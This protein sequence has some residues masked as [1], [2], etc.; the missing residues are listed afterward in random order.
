MTTPAPSL[1]QPLPLP[2]PAK[3]TAWLRVRYVL[4]WIWFPP[5]WL[6]LLIPSLVVFAAWWALCFVSAE[7]DGPSLMLFTGRRFRWRRRMWLDRKRMRRSGSKDLLRLEDELRA[8]FDGRKKVAG[9]FEWR[10]GGTLWRHD[11]GRLEIDR[12]FFRQPGA[13]RALEIAG[14]YGVVPTDGGKGLP[15]WLVLK[16]GQQHAVRSAPEQRQ[17]SATD[18][19]YE[20]QAGPYAAPRPNQPPPGGNPY[21]R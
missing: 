1:A 3:S 10:T 5:V 15:V 2:G 8:L 16:G 13:A 6:I 4:Q 20:Q 21:R 7:A 14:E 19:P 11:D 18:Q 12:S 17:T 9:G